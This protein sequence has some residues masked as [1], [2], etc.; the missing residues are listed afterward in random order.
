M[1]ALLV[2]P[3]VGSGSVVCAPLCGLGAGCTGCGCASAPAARRSA[4]AA[5]RVNRLSRAAIGAPSPSEFLRLDALRRGV[6]RLLRRLFRPGSGV[7]ALL[8]GKRPMLLVLAA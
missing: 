3:R 1:S 7:A 6:E 8:Q 2:R 4:A 5:A